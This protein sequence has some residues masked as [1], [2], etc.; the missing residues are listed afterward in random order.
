M[1]EA[2]LH[3]ILYQVPTNIDLSMLVLTCI[4]GEGTALQ[5]MEVDKKV[6]EV[7]VEEEEESDVVGEVV[8][9]HVHDVVQRVLPAGGLGLALQHRRVRRGRPR[10]LPEQQ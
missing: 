10:L 6:V 9:P 3:L 4:E 2:H 8:L 5:M 1:D 7:V